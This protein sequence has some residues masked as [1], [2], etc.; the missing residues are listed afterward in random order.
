MDL[1]PE[2]FVRLYLASGAFVSVVAILSILVTA[3]GRD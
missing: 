1:H 2:I 3:R